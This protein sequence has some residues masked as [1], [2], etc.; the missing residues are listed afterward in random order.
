VGATRTCNAEEKCDG[1]KSEPVG[2]TCHHAFSL[3]LEIAFRGGRSPDRIF[4]D[5]A[6]NCG[7]HPCRPAASS[8]SVSP[9]IALS[10]AA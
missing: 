4:A 6:R 1:K 7:W 5:L 10:R 9:P 3:R 8:A 2:F